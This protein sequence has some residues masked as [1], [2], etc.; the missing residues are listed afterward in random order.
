[1]IRSLHKER[2]LNI[3]HFFFTLCFVFGSFGIYEN[4]KKYKIQEKKTLEEK[5]NLLDQEKTQAIEKLKQLQLH[6]NSLNDPL[7]VE[8]VL[9][10][11]LGVVPEG[12][13]KV[14]FKDKKGSP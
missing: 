4:A 2:S 1:M 6:V 9:I 10:E 14:I 5:R 8:L 13:N 11:K 3:L 12:H 7:W